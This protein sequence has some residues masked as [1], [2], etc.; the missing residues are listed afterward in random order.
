MIV[1]NIFSDKKV[2]N[3]YNDYP[4]AILGLGNVLVGAVSINYAFLYD[5]CKGSKFPLYFILNFVGNYFDTIKYLKS[6]EA[7]K[8]FFNKK[9]YV[10]GYIIS[11]AIISLVKT[12]MPPMIIVGPFCIIVSLSTALFKKQLKEFWYGTPVRYN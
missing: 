6:F 7:L 5:Y 12:P 11:G 2:C 3:Y 4:Y 1:P 8:K 10:L 9:A